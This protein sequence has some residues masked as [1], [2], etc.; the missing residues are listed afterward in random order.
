M[1]KSLLLLI[2]V[3]FF[4]AMPVALG[5]GTFEITH[6]EE[7]RI[8]S[9]D[10]LQTYTDVNVSF[11][12][13][14]LIDAY[15]LNFDLVCDDIDSSDYGNVVYRYTTDIVGSYEY[16]ASMDG[17][18]DGIVEW[19]DD[20]LPCFTTYYGATCAG[21]GCP[22]CCDTCDLNGDGVVNALDFSLATVAG[23][24]LY[25]FNFSVNWTSY[26]F[27]SAQYHF[28]YSLYNQTDHLQESG[29]GGNFY[30]GGTKTYDYHFSIMEC[31]PAHL[32][33]YGNIPLNGCTFKVLSN[34]DETHALDIISAWFADN[35]WTAGN[36]MYRQLQSYGTRQVFYQNEDNEP[37]WQSFVHKGDIFKANYPYYVYYGVRYGAGVYSTVFNSENTHFTVMDASCYPTNFSVT[38]IADPYHVHEDH[39]KNWKWIGVGRYFE[40]MTGD[41]DNPLTGWQLHTPRPDADSFGDMID[42]WATD[43]TAWGGEPPMPWFKT[44]VGI[45][46]CVISICIPLGTAIRY[47]LEIP[48]FIYG[49]AL[50]VGMFGAF[51]LELFEIWHVATYLIM[52]IFTLVYM[53]RETLFSAVGIV[54]ADEEL[55]I[56]EKDSRFRTAEDKN[57]RAFVGKDKQTKT[58]NVSKKRFWVARKLSG[59]KTQRMPRTDRRIKYSQKGTG[60]GYSK[61]SGYATASESHADW[62]KRRGK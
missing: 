28:A 48:N 1:N 29:S 31:Y 18:G 23:T 34:R 62:K 57:V 25:Y 39:T 24:E 6:P 58:E 5:A 16:N 43:P 47:D 3:V 49:I 19:Y 10:Y 50:T 60:S 36:Y 33:Y 13:N 21:V 17:D 35:P 2:G 59:N 38:R 20:L 41:D 9:L 52:V 37:L 14:H 26:P 22:S 15:Y 12:F 56:Q 30:S 11:Q 42:A 53:Y 4:M 8:Y 40:T 51:A 46:I 61:K 45:I 55:T 54:Q 27:D 44:I 7:G 32:N